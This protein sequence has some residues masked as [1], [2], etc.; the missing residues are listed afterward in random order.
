M[1]PVSYAACVLIS[2]AILRTMY[3]EELRSSDEIA[4]HF[5]CSATTV[6]RRLR[7]F[8]IAVRPRGPCIERI[9]IRNDR[10]QPAW[11]A[12]VAYVVGLI[13]TDGNLGRKKPMITIVSKD[14]D[15][16]ET[17][18]H[19]LGIT[20]PIRRHSGGERDRCHHL[21]WHARS[22]YEWL[23]EIGLTPAKS[24]TLRPLN[25]PDEYFADFFRG[26]IDGDGTILVYTDRYHVPKC[27]RY[28]YER[29]YLSIVSASYAFIEWLRTT[30]QRLATVNGSIGVRQ[31]RGAHSIWQLR[32]AKAEAIQLL[33][34]MYYA[35]DVP[36]LNRKRV[37]AEKFLRPL[38]RTSQRLTGRP[39]IGWLYNAESENPKRRTDRAGVE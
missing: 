25:V 21:C 11:S 14:I 33:R 32:Y 36:C 22:L 13:A 38:G 26:C 28:V 10:A 29:L 16:L 5:G 15:L 37:K 3:L 24:L 31:R 17:V 20:T 19:C 4:T 7:R 34:W 39:R 18:R 2:P 30:V 35:S 12:Q 9:R 6:R 27:D 23:L 1:P 8:K